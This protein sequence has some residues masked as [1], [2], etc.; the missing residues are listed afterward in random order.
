MLAA[1]HIKRPV[2]AAIQFLEQPDR[3]HVVALGGGDLLVLGDGDFDAAAAHVDEDWNVAQW[4]ADEEAMSR[5]AAKQ[6]DYEAAVRI[7]QAVDA[8]L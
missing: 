8:A 3:A 4:G 2:V 1:Q 5:R 7:L 6:I